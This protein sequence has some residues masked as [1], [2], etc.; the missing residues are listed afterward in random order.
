MKFYA[1][2]PDVKNLYFWLGRAKIFF[3][4][5]FFFFHIASVRTIFS[6]QCVNLEMDHAH[7]RR[8]WYSAVF[9]RY[10]AGPGFDTMLHNYK[11][12]W[13]K[14]NVSK[15]KRNFARRSSRIWKLSIAALEKIETFRFGRCSKAIVFLYKTYNENV[16]YCVGIFSAA[17]CPVNE[18]VYR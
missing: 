7:R 3:L 4:F 2:S 10:F 18:T 1:R 16:S 15:L 17:K 12:S 8:F 14:I 11:I 9:G 6:T 5:C 13:H